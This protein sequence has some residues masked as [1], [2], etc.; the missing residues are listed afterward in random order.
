AFSCLAIQSLPYPPAGFYTIKVGFPTLTS[1]P[2]FGV[3]YTRHQKTGNDREAGLNSAGF[4]IFMA[5]LFI[6]DMIP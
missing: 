2:V 6:F 3:H 4:L 1:C 5:L